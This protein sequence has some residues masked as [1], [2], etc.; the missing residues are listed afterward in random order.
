MDQETDIFEE[1]QRAKQGGTNGFVLTTPSPTLIW[2]NDFMKHLTWWTC[3]WW[4]LI[5]LP[6]F[7]EMTRVCTEIPD[8]PVE[9]RNR[10]LHHKTS[11]QK[12][13]ISVKFHNSVMIFLNKFILN[14]DGKAYHKI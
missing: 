5:S 11:R 10:L 14:L 4:K 13:V 1:Q 6:K 9:A 7:A 12:T 3:F 2:L 8:R